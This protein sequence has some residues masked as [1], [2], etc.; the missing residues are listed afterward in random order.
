MSQVI[1]AESQTRLRGLIAVL[2]A[3]KGVS[4]SEARDAVQAL[5]LLKENPGTSLLL[6]DMSDSNGH[7]FLEDAL[8][9]RP[10]LKLL[11]LITHAG[12]RP[13]PAALRAREMR[14]VVKPF[15]PERLCA[16]VAEMLA[17]P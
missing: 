11:I 8:K 5:Q 16:L 10:E 14:T 7:S 1:L 15:D 17:R 12:E 9:L 2:L 4:V 6:C 13:P 3:G